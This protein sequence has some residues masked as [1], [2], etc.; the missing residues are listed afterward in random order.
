MISSPAIHT[1]RPDRVDRLSAF[2]N[3]FE[4]QVRVPNSPED[5]CNLF[6]VASSDQSERRLVFYPHQTA[7]REVL[8]GVLVAAEV[9]FGGIANP[10]LSSLP[11]ELTLTAFARD[12]LW[13]L[14]SH[15]LDEAHQPRCGGDAALARLGELLVL[16]LLRSAIDKGSTQPGV[17]AGLAHPKLR[18]GVAAMLEDPG[19]PWRVEVLAEH[20]GMSR[21]QFMLVFPQCLGVPP[22]AFLSA[23]RMTLARRSL[24]A[25]DRVKAVAQMAGY[26][27]PAAFSRAYS[28]TF[29]TAP[30]SSRSSV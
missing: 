8:T 15:F 1:E 25:G 24:E 22:G 30:K 20:C 19:K 23:W 5:A 14:T 13:S 9:E 2:L 10:L 17:L 26:A 27:S 11:D 3:A 28:R 29:G 16:M 21:S 4:L 7:R 12:S 6:V 18:A